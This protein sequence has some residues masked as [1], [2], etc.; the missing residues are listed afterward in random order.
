LTVGS[1]TTSAAAISSLDRP[2]TMIADRY[3]FPAGNP[4]FAPP[5][6]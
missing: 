6:P 1:D 5:R 2:R 3:L 4:R